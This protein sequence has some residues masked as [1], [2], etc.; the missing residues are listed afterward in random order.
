MT[1][2]DLRKYNQPATADALKIVKNDFF[3]IMDTLRHFCFT[4]ARRRS[5]YFLSNVFFFLCL[6]GMN[7]R[8]K[9]QQNAFS[10]S[11]IQKWRLP[12]KAILS[13]VIYHTTLSQ[14]NVTL[15]SWFESIFTTHPD[16]L[17]LLRTHTQKNVKYIYGCSRLENLSWKCHIANR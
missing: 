10:D 11:C 14:K 2:A 13:F 1:S 4:S 16:R 5:T 6:N 12:R 17:H 9:I 8:K 15:R 3:L 7:Q